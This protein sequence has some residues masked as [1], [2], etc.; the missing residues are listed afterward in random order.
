MKNIFFTILFLGS[1]AIFA[2]DT[3]PTTKVSENIGKEVWVKGVIASIKIA[4]EGKNTNYLNIDQPYP[5]AVF[6]VVISNKYAEE[7]LL[8]LSESKG[9]KIIGLYRPQEDK[10]LSAMIAGNSYVEVVKDENVS[11]LPAV[12]DKVLN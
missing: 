12:F 2:Q 3:I 9:K 1:S 4:S 5:D 7:H 6:T 11:E 8:N 10:R